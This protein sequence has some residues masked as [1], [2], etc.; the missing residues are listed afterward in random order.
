VNKG[1]AERPR[2]RIIA[3]VV[4][5]CRAFVMSSGSDQRDAW[6]G[7]EVRRVLG[8]GWAINTL[9]EIFGILYLHPRAVLRPRAGEGSDLIIFRICSDG[10]KNGN[11]VLF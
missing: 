6:T 10:G 9:G 3:I 5:V 2:P 7:E 1:S 4:P 8:C 11:K